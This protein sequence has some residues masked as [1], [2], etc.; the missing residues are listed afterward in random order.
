MNK[1]GL[2]IQHHASSTLKGQ[3]GDEILPISFF[4]A[5]CK[6]KSKGEV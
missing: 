3:G 6:E 1:Q 4:G 2:F 5:N